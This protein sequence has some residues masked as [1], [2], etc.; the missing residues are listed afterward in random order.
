M[1]S[2][3]VAAL[4][5]VFLL[6]WPSALLPGA[7]RHVSPLVLPEGATPLPFFNSPPSR[8]PAATPAPSSDPPPLPT[9]ANFAFAP[10]TPTAAPPEQP[11]PTVVRRPVSIPTAPGP[12]ATEVP[13]S[14]AVP[15]GARTPEPRATPVPR[16]DPTKIPAPTPT[17]PVTDGPRPTLPPAPTVSRPPTATPTPAATV[18]SCQDKHEAKKADA[19]N[20]ARCDS[21]EAQDVRDGTPSKQQAKHQADQVGRPRRD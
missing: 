19:N 10:A 4:I 17:E 18:S 1:V 20:D 2:A 13:T 11:Q 7:T 14:G 5:V 3:V 8:L 16:S 6:G 21:D 9:S 15:P 12:Q